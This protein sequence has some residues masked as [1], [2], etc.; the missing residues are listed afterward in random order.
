MLVYLLYV[1]L[2]IFTGIWYIYG[3]L[4]Y[5]WPFGI[6]MAIRYIY[7]HLVYLWPFGIFVGYLV[8]S[9]P[10]LVHCRK[11]LATT[12]AIAVSTDGNHL[13]RPRPAVG[14]KVITMRNS[15]VW[16]KWMQHKTFHDSRMIFLFFFCG[17]PRWRNG[18]ALRKGP[19]PSVRELF[20][21]CL[22]ILCEHLFH[23]NYKQ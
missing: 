19:Y 2:V 7:G 21:L 11:N 20:F 22:Q 17:L 14:V 15:T 18:Q 9:F 13:L 23:S 4:V 16:L 1:H 8:C 12:S 5:L 6:F 10:V 3:H